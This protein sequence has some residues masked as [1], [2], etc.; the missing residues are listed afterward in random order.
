MSFIRLA[1]A[2]L[3]LAMFISLPPPA[4]A[5][6]EDLGGILEDILGG[7]Q[8]PGQTPIYGES[9][10]ENVPVIIRYDAP[11]D[12]SHN[13]SD[14]IL[15][16]SAYVPSEADGGTTKPRM[17]GQ[18][19]LLMTGLEQPLQITIAAPRNVTQDLIFSRITAEVL[20]E[21]KNQVLIAAR[22][23]IY[24]GKETPEL[25]LIPSNTLPAVPTQRDYVSFETITGE[26]LL[27]DRKAQ[28]NGGTLTLQLLENALAGGTSLTIAAEKNLSLEGAALPVAFT[29]DHGV[30]DPQTQIPL[31]LNAW[32]TD[33]AGRK[34][35]VMRRPVPYNGPD[36]DYKL[37]LDVLAQGSDTRA[38]RELGPNLMTQTVV[39]GEAL[40]DVRSGLP[41]EARLKV[42]LNRAV[43]AVG[44]NRLLS[45]QT[46]IVRG[47]EGRVPFTLSTASTNFD[48]LVPAPLL[49]LQI[50]DRNGGIYF[51]SGHI[52]AREGPQNIQLYARRN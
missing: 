1:I 51:D 21:N 12:N 32:I 38:G 40:F 49:N 15:V 35:H 18:T 41:A 8:L 27:N 3:S 22:D 42:T 25:T 33:W 43:G 20:D 5:Q 28:V 6:F 17:L 19:R 10:V 29:L 44:Q 16:V 30:T 31:V 50:I 46:I 2:A 11:S 37:K 34:T 23:G 36:I 45:T 39:S 26:V 7:G 24:R 4:Q 52:Q 14:H 9:G 47:F 13:Y 48:P